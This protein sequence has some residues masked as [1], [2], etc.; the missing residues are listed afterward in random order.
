MSNARVLV[1]MFF[2]V[3]AASC[4]DASL[5][6]VQPMGNDLKVSGEFCTSAPKSMNV[7]TR[8][9]FVIDNSN[10]MRQVSDPDGDRFTAVER[11][12]DAY[13]GADNVE[14]AIIC[15][16]NTAT[17]ETAGGFTKDR[18]ELEAA[19]ASCRD[20]QNQR[21]DGTNYIAALAA[22][23]DLI[24]ADGTESERV[25][26]L[27]ELITDG[28]PTADDLEVE[29]I[30]GR[31][32]NEVGLIL[33]AGADQGAGRTRLDVLLFA[34]Y[35]QVPDLFIDLLPR[36]ATLGGGS[37]LQVYDP[38]LVLDTLQALAKAEIW[39]QSFELRDLFVVS[40]NVR[41]TRVDSV[42]A[43]VQAY[44]D[45]DGDG[46][47]DLAELELGTAPDD[48]D[49]DAD[50]ASDLVE[51]EVENRD[52]TLAEL[53]ASGHDVDDALDVDRDGLNG[54]EERLLG[55][56]PQNPDTDNDAM[57]DGLEVLFAT[58]PL[59]PDDRA[60]YDKDNVANIDE[61][62]QHTNPRLDEGSDLRRDF[63]YRSAG[64]TLIEQ[65]ESRSCYSF[66]VE[67]L[68]LGEIP[69]VPGLRAAGGNHIEVIF[70]DKPV[71]GPRV[72]TH[73]AC[74]ATTAMTYRDGRR[75]PNRV[76]LL[77]DRD[78]FCD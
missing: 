40:E 24:A 53:E 47:V 76:E 74:A 32:Y 75:D 13:A 17:L 66:A 39:L 6:V 36:M 48:R 10:S 49:S 14:S 64:V 57:P 9:A 63:A 30:P 1:P 59:R 62:K 54:Y 34:A 56:D 8:I 42:A 71:G 11:I 60:D 28:M 7:S 3:A 65:A 31:I 12:V 52:P 67:N 37:F 27:V 45:T 46:L 44:I 18:A 55:L 4:T 29:A 23:R 19:L 61:L 25:D 68:R 58:D 20:A 5:R 70:I 50:G 38:S 41:L 22:T 77:M 73:G 51:L 33:D 2:V 43:E 26:Y 72:T 16:A 21:D 15:W 78:A 35:I 69:A